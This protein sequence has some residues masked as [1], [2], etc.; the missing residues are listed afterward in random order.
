MNYI[1]S[2][3]HDLALAPLLSIVDATQRVGQRVHPHHGGSGYLLSARAIR[4]LVFLIQLQTI[5]RNMSLLSVKI[6]SF[7]TS[8]KVNSLEFK[9]KEFTLARCLSMIAC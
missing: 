7:Y 8:F 3:D 9:N 2:P 5:Y 6:F 4:W 1:T